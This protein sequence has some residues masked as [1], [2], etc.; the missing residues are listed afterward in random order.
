VLELS[1]EQI[2]RV[3]AAYVGQGFEGDAHG[4]PPLEELLTAA[5]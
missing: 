3:R 5:N 2:P 1:S 4:L